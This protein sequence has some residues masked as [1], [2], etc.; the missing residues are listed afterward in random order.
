[1]KKKEDNIKN[2]RNIKDNINQKLKIYANKNKKNNKSYYEEFYEVYNYLINIETV[3]PQ[4]IPIDKIIEKFVDYLYNY[5]I[6]SKNNLEENFIFETIYKK[7]NEKVKIVLQIA[8]PCEEG[9]LEE[10]KNR[11]KNQ[12]NKPGK[13]FNF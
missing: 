11:E 1:M 4:T 10:D 7:E 3:K 8:S 9:V 13:L 12:Q 6:N 2:F 5:Y